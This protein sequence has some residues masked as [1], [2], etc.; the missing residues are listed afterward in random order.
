[1][2]QSNL[3][4]AAIS[5]ENKTAVDNALNT[6][7]AALKDILVFNLTPDQRTAMLKMGDKTLAFVDKALE[8][9][10]Q[11]P[12]LV[13]QYVDIPE[14]EKDL[15]LTRD[16]FHIYQKLTALT[17]SVEDAMMVAGGEAYEAS[18]IF[19]NSVKGASRSNAA[20]SQAIYE[21]MQKRF[22]RRSKKGSGNTD[23]NTQA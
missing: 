14:A 23:I 22:P 6:V 7:A 11:N 20:G 21:E 8:Y 12:N 2:G 13:P 16:L 3:I 4:S 17:R 1:M 9:A 19:Y 18:L 5:N 15:A 10:R